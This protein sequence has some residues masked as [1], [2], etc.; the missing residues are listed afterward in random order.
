MTYYKY[1]N[2]LKTSIKSNLGNISK[3]NLKFWNNNLPTFLFFFHTES[4]QIHP[5]PPAMKHED[6]G[7]YFSH[8]LN[9]SRYKA[10]KPLLD[11]YIEDYAD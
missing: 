11:K 8:L 10:S 3:K 2:K 1:N 5:N 7:K 9:P 4:L 6:V